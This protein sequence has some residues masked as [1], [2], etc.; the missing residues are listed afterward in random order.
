MTQPNFLRN[1]LLAAA[2]LATSLG[3]FAQTTATWIGPATGGEW[4]TSSAWNTLLAPADATTNAFIGAG[5]NVSY[6]LPMTAASFGGVTN[7]GTLNLNT[8][9]FNTTAIVMNTAGGGAKLFINNGA[10]VNVAGNVGFTSNSVATFNSGSTI[11]ISG[12]LYVGSGSAGGSG[13]GTVSSYAIVTNNGATLNASATALNVANQSVTA[14]ALL[15]I[16]GGANNLGNVA[17]SRGTGGN[18]SPPTL[19]T[20][21]LVINNGTVTLTNL[22]TTSNS[23]QTMDMTGGIVTNWGTFKLNQ[24][25]GLRTTRF[26]QSGGLFVNPSANNM[27]LLPTSGTA[28]ALYQVTGGTNM[29]NG[30]QFGDAVPSAGVTT[31]TVG[32]PIFIGAGGMNSNGAVTLTASLNTGGRLAASADWTN[33]VTVT[34]NGGTFDAQ[35]A[36]GTPHNIYSSGTLKTGALIKNGGGVLTLTA[37][38]NTPS[39]TT[40]NAGTLAL[41]IDANGS[42]G[43]VPN[44][45]L[46]ASNATLDVS[47]LNSVGG[48][49]LG[50]TRTLSGGGTVTGTF[51]ATAGSI[52]SPAGTSA[53]GGINFAT[54]LNA[55]NSTFNFELTDDTTG[56][57]KRND[58]INI[59][60]DLN[61][62]GINSIAV[63][64]VGSLAIGTYNLIHF[65]GALYGDISNFSCSSGTLTNPPGSGDINLIVTSVRASANLIWRGDG[66][67]N[68]WDTAIT[69][70]WLNGAALDRSYNGD[71]NTFNDTATNFTVNLF[72]NVSPASSGTVLVNATNNYTFTGSGQIL[73]ATSLTKTNS[74]TLTILNT[75]NFSGGIN[76]KGGTIS[77]ASLA[78]DGTVSPLG[79]T[80]TILLDGGTL[81]YSGPN[82]AWTRSFTLGAN[83]GT[84]TAANILSQGGL[85]IISGAGALIKSSAGG[86]TLNNANTYTGGTIL[87]NGT[88]TLNNAS[89]ASSGNITLNGGN[90]ALG[91]VK[92]ANTISVNGAATITGG[93]AGGN[94][95]IKNVIGSANLTLLINGGSTFDLNGDMT[96]YSGTI[97]LTNGNGNFV[98]F[99][100]ATG[101]S[102]ATWNLVG[103]PIDLNVRAGTTAINLGGLSGVAGSTLSGRGGSGNNGA[104]TFTIGANG[105]NTVFDGIIQNGGGGSSSITHITK[106]GSGTLTLSGANSYSGTTTINGGTLALTG[107]GSI[108]NSAT[109]DVQTGATLDIST[110]FTPTL[111][112]GSQTL[113]GRGTILGALDASNGNSIIAP[114]G[115]IGGSTGTLTVT[116]AITLGG[117]AWM[118][119]NRT[120]SPNSDRL[121][122]SLSTITCGGTLQV[123]NIGDAL[124]LGDSFT[125]FNAAGGL[126]GSFTTTNLPTLNA[127]LGWNWD[128]ATAQLTVVA[129]VNLTPAPIVSTVSGSTLTL[130]WPTDHIGWHLQAQT[131]NLS[132]GLTGSWIDISGTDTS[133][134]YNATIDPAN[135]TVFY[136]LVYP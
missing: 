121:V 89:S 31:L 26:V 8:N 45:I 107:S 114:G 123:T 113:R 78:D 128:P 6:N 36:S 116:N 44:S 112:L 122:S 28:I 71:T 19:G 65:T 3:A 15:V 57:I 9:G 76:L 126:T 4:S 85:S 39:S 96:A 74:G 37:A 87:N 93:N 82:Y 51:A 66:I 105:Q 43:S 101:S 13:S 10:V 98:R 73:G 88:L 38:N 86:L 59:A 97:S 115:G 33:N 35:D 103:N 68:Q 117:T 12:S 104:T 56:T 24:P 27:S 120:N 34:L 53:Q 109:I 134:S 130:S 127:G 136:R 99:N 133:N 21:G 20:D 132:T 7:R 18:S 32:A 1:S 131:N 75:N 63:T 50:S 79:V 129:T 40:V 102:L 30:F 119:L 70:D 64:A 14:N 83:N 61:V 42:V 55:T 17:I 84:I 111:A 81:D 92:P 5:T 48:F 60:G 77:V 47:G 90:L 80:G 22:N 106:T 95:G 11:N 91:A 23:H 52:V 135:G 54:G 2:L 29:V 72:G 67:G 124:Q 41:A 118:K 108:A 49:T 100:G 125:L 62:G 25:T 69:S 94:T 16:N 58:F 46:V 110:T